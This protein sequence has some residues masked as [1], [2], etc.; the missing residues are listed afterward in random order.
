MAALRVEK[1]HMIRITS[2]AFSCLFLAVTISGC[3][4][5]G[6]PQITHSVVEPSELGPGQ[7]ALITV[8]L[9]DTN[10]IVDHIDGVVKNYPE[11]KFRL[12]DD[13]TAPDVAAGDGIWTMEVSVPFQAPPGEHF[14]NFTAYDNQ[15]REIIVP[16][17]DGHATALG[18]IL[19]VVIAYPSDEEE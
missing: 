18:T 1:S 4:T 12:I 17:E 19:R 10:S 15:G 8:E 3:A 11:R 13:G 5:T 6:I 16:D 7:I 9:K 14:I 2:M